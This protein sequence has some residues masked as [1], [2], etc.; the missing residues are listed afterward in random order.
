MLLEDLG[1]L[2]DI[3]LDIQIKFQ[4]FYNRLWIFPGYTPTVTGNCS[5]KN[6]SAAKFD[7]FVSYANDKGA[8]WV[9]SDTVQFNN[10][11]VYDSTDTGID[12]KSMKNHA[13]I[14]SYNAPTFYSETSGSLISDSVI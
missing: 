10:F 12:T 3:I 13:A 11:L 7:T 14:N 1:M 5:D 8:E 6:P 4:L 9:E 2:F